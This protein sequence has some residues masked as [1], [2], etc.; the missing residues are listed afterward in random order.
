MTTA[1]QFAPIWNSSGTNYTA[2]R[3]NVTDVASSGGSM[4][5]DLRLNNNSLFSVGKTGAVTQGPTQLNT[6]VSTNRGLIVQ[7]A[8][9]QSANL[10]EWRDVS[11]AVLAS[12]DR[13]GDITA[14]TGAFH[15]VQITS[16]LPR[17]SGLLF[18]DNGT[19]NTSSNFIHDRSN[20]ASPKLVFRASG[21]A[22]PD[23]SL[24]ILTSASG[25]SSGVQT[26]SFEGSAGQLFSISDVL[27]SGTIFGVNDISGL[28]LLEVDATGLVSLARFGTNIV[29]HTPI[30]LGGTTSSFPSIR[31]NGSDVRFRL[32]DNSA[33]S[34]VLARGIYF[35][36]GNAGI[37][38][39]ANNF[40]IFDIG[41]NDRGYWGGDFGV[42]VGNEGY[43]WVNG[44]WYGTKHG[45]FGPSS[46]VVELRGGTN[47]Q[48][49]R[50]YNAFT[51]SSN[52]ER[53]RLE[54]SSNSVKIGTEAAGTGSVR[55]LE[56]WAGTMAFFFGT[57]NVSFLRSLQSDT[58]NAVDVGATNRRFRTLMLGTSIDNLGFEQFTEMTPPTT[59]AANSCRIYAKD[60]GSGKTQLVVLM[61]DGV[62][63]V[64]VTQT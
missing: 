3:A 28:P 61:P 59:P 24:N 49:F 29:A 9:A 20:P 55:T 25:S 50:I 56:F 8:A 42:P 5:M 33:D 17:Q 30:S 53:L 46:H 38:Q 37:K 7:G 16:T 41:G 23:I 40:L 1:T 57:G 63:T 26:L 35:N 27:N 60:N 13:D 19:L 54:W 64:L 48:T 47:S 32:A 52:Y 51:D 2:I 36:G 4:L 12:V 31:R 14:A 39:T 45:F 22:T 11:G 10:Q 34:N 18:L 6:L 21:N 44:N 62:E 58:N 43:T 15:T